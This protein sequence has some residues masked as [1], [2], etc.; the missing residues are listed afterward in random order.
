ML[1][2]GRDGPN[3]GRGL[4]RA[5]NLQIHGGHFAS[6]GRDVHNHVYQAPSRRPF[7][8]LSALESVDNHRRIQQDTLAKA[9]AKTGEWIFQRAILHGWLKIESDV[10]EFGFEI[11]RDVDGLWLGLRPRAAP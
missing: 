9:T 5:Q 8:L 1:H 4:I 7:D 6:A 2:S 3:V 10:D 11:I